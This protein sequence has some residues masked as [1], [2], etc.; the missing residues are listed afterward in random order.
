MSTLKEKFANFEVKPDN[1]VWSSIENTITRRKVVLRRQRIAVAAASLAL[2]G[3][4]AIFALAGNNRQTEKTSAQAQETNIQ[5]FVVE[6]QNA[7]RQEPS[8]AA[9]AQSEA[10]ATSKAMAPD[11]TTKATPTTNIVESDAVQPV[12]QEAPVIVQPTINAKPVSTVQPSKSA[13]QTVADNHPTVQDNTEVQQANNE[14][15][16]SQPKVS[17]EPQK[18]VNEE[19]VVWI[20]NAFAPDDPN[21]EVR[22]FKVKPNSEANLLSYEIFIYSRAGRLVYHSKDVNDGWDGISYGHAQPMGTYV[23]IIEINDAVKGI[24]HKKGTIT[25]IR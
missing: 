14:A 5:S 12:A 15:Q 6:N 2:G 22:T 13:S 3:V 21:D 4:I 7:Y 25:L 23:Y 8:T 9:T 10:V 24:Q 1:K 19:L 17:R 11:K 18:V 16:Q 20:P